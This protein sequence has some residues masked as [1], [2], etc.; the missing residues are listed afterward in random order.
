MSLLN[1]YRE[2]RKMTRPIDE[3]GYLVYCE[4]RAGQSLA[5]LDDRTLAFVEAYVRTIVP[6]LMDTS[7]GSHG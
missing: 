2:T 7:K 4:L 1:D 3:G 6:L 5:L